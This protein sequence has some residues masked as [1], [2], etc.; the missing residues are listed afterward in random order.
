V[1]PR[2]PVFG[3]PHSSLRKAPTGLL[4]NS[5]A[6]AMDLDPNP[7]PYLSRF[8]FPE[9]YPITQNP[10]SIII[11]SKRECGITGTGYVAALSNQ[12]SSMQR[13]D[14]PH[15]D[16]PRVILNAVGRDAACDAEH[17][18]TREISPISEEDWPKMRDFLGIT[19]SRCVWFPK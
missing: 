19:T 1:L 4:A 8:T 11:R 13:T 12:F 18:A 7:D 3:F 16:C 2:L 9:A 6:I 15:A 17:L 5:G 10:Y 14:L